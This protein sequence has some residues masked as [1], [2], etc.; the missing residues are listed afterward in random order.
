MLLGPV[1]GV[2]ALQP[3]SSMAAS[4]NPIAMRMLP[5][6]TIRQAPYPGF[7]RSRLLKAEDASVCRTRQAF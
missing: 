1:P 7:P 2:T 4:N 3:A 5:S 6:L